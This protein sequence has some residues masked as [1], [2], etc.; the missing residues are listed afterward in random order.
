VSRG[1]RLR[2]FSSCKLPDADQHPPALRRILL[3][4]HYNPRSRP[5]LPLTRH[6]PS[7]QFLP[8]ILQGGGYNVKESLLLSAPPY[9][10]AAIYTA[11]SAHFSD[12]TRQRALFIGGSALLCIVGLCILAF[13]EGLAVRYFGSFLTI[14]GCQANV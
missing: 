6:L 13:P 8:V 9:A 10:A 14:M 2:M 7:R 5:R 12:K 4:E 3:R 11:I 1:F